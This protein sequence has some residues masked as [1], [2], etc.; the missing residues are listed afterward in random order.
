VSVFFL[1][2]LHGQIRDRRRGGRTGVSAMRNL[3]SPGRNFFKS[4][5]EVRGELLGKHQQPEV[6][7][8]F[9]PLRVVQELQGQIRDSAGRDRRRL[10]PR[11]LLQTLTDD[12]T[13]ADA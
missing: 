3:P 12:L 8:E 10:L 7:P 5:G 2:E 6:P 4:G 13:S 11:R 9:L 1:Q